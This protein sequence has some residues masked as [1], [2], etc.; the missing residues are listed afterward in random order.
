M[1]YRM[2]AKTSTTPSLWFGAFLQKGDVAEAR[3]QLMEIADSCGGP[4]DDYK[5]LVK[6]IVEHVTGEANVEV[7]GVRPRLVPRCAPCRR[8]RGRNDGRSHAPAHG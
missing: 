1:K 4:C 5:L 7:V 6:A 8:R 2:P 3:E